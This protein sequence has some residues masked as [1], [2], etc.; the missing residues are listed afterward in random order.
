[1][2][3]KKKGKKSKKVTTESRTRGNS[4]A[5]QVIEIVKSSKDFYVGF[6]DPLCYVGHCIHCNT[7]ITVSMDG[8][9][10]ATIE[11]IMPICAGGSVT[12]LRN[13]ALACKTCNNKKGVHH[14]AKNLNQR[15]FEVISSLLE[16]RKSSMIN[17]EHE[18]GK[19]NI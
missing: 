4:R 3:L 7:M 11:H 16:K 15:A 14:D 18:T 6:T 1:M 12:D 10:N 8:K 17:V 19:L 9:T 2:G 5:A 13:L